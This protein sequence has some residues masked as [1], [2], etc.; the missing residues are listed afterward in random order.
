MASPERFFKGWHNLPA[1]NVSETDKEYK[2]EVAI[3]GFKKEE[4]KVNLE[5]E[6]LT[7]SAENKSEKEEKAKRYTRKE[8][9]Y[10]SSTRSF[11]LPKAANAEKIEAKYENGL[12]KLAIAKKDDSISKAGKE[13]RID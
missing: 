10:G 2:I 6:V 7:I 3:P 8:F 13:I 5:N 11:Q 9:F 12:L 4:V 1:A